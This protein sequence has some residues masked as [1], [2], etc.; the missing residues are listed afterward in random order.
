MSKK[1]HIKAA[2]KLATLNPDDP[3]IL[4][5]LLQT[6]SVVESICKWNA[7]R[8]DQSHDYDLALALLQEELCET[9]EALEAS[10]TVAILDGFGDIFYVAVGA[11]WKNG[12]D[13]SQISALLDHLDTTNVY[14]PNTA[15]CVMWFHTEPGI[16][17]LGFVALSAFESLKY[18]L[19]QSDQRAL[20]VIRAICISNNTKEVVRTAS[21]VKANVVKG[22][23]YIAPTRMLQTILDSLP[24]VPDAV[25]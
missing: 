11:M 4:Q 7:A 9:Q 19:Q 20:D 1:E 10:D 18:F 13:H 25:S 17:T 2:S 15:T 6:D 23:G 3:T 8:Y 22:D 14:V 12:A 16:N 21:D 24:E 5:R